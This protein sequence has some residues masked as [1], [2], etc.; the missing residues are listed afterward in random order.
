[1]FVKR[2]LCFDTVAFQTSFGWS[3]IKKK[4]KASLVSAVCVCYSVCW[5][6]VQ[7]PCSTQVY[8]YFF[9]VFRQA[10][11]PRCTRDA[12]YFKRG[13]PSAKPRKKKQAI[14]YTASAFSRALAL[15]SVPCVAEAVGVECPGQ[16]PHHLGRGAKERSHSLLSACFSA[17]S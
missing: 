13:G 16:S 2:A 15:S 9:L 17:L 11:I 6:A 3:E 5:S 4:K 8:M 7:L 10:D 14:A 1:M 12:L